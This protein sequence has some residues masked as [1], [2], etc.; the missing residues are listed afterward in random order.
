MTS[1]QSRALL[2]IGLCA[3]ALAGCGDGGRLVGTAPGPPQILELTVPSSIRANEILDI[4]FRATSDVGITSAEVSA[5][6][7][8]VQDTTLRFDPAETSLDG[9]TQFRMPPTITRLAV[10]VRVVVE[11]RRG[12]RSDP[13]EV[14]VPVV[15]DG[16]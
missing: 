4:G 9:F 8:V 10:R 15:A 14:D 6:S 13:V 16:F 12:A 1:L 3:A 2:T 11:D 5:V 7:D